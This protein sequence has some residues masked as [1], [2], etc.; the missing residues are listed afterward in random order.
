[1]HSNEAVRAMGSR[2]QEALSI[3][4]ICR[5]GDVP[6]GTRMSGRAVC[7]SCA[8]RARAALKQALESAKRAGWRGP[9]V[10]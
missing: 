2:V 3:L 9:D 4:E 6:L 8:D 5:H 1:M 10:F 7:E